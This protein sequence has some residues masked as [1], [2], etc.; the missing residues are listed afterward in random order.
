MYETDFLASPEFPA[1]EAVDKRFDKE[2]QKVTLNA[3]QTIPNVGHGNKMKDLSVAFSLD[4]VT[5]HSQYKIKDF[6]VV[7]FDGTDIS[8]LFVGNQK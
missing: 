8:D 6:N 2:Q 1:A 5:A 4:D 3:M 7:K